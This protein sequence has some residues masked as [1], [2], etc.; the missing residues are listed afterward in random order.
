LFFTA[1]AYDQSKFNIND[2]KLTLMNSVGRVAPV[3]FSNVKLSTYQVQWGFYKSQE[4]YTMEDEVPTKDD[5]F[6]A[7]A[8]IAAKDL[9]V[10]KFNI[11]KFIDFDG[12]KEDIKAAWKEIKEGRPYA[13]KDEAIKTIGRAAAKILINFYSG[14][15]SS[16]NTDTKNM[17]YS[18]QKLVL[19]KVTEDGT[20]PQH[21][22]QDNGN[23]QWRSDE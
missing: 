21:H 6:E 9:D 16:N 23:G 11:K 20:E 19:S 1:K 18:P 10:N 12:M 17:S 4:I 15:M 22:T 14:K 3:T 7:D 13:T 5:W 8:T 2:Y